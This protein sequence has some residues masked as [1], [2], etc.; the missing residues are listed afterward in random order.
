M[1]SLLS[2]IKQP[3]S[4]CRF[5]PKTLHRLPHTLPSREE[6]TFL[7]VFD[8]MAYGRKRKVPFIRMSGTILYYI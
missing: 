5:D 3:S 2:I 1:E 4:P 6:E 8:F 7:Y